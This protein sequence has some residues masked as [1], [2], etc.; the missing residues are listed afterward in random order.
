MAG[1]RGGRPPGALQSKGPRRR[2]ACDA[3]YASAS[4]KHAQKYEELFKLA[5]QNVEE[6]END[7][8]DEDNTDNFQLDDN[9]DD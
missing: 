2:L 9:P 7:L 5:D 8:V 4:F 6:L 3:E 1:G